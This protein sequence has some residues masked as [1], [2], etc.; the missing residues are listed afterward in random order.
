MK[1]IVLWMICSDGWEW[2]ENV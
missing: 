1:V 2:G